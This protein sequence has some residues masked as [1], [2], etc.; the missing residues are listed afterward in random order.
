MKNLIWFII[1]ASTV[2]SCRPEPI[3]VRNYHVEFPATV[4]PAQDTFNIGDTI[5]YEL[6]VA[7][8]VE[9][10]QTSEWIDI[11]ML[12]LYFV[13]DISRFDTLYTNFSLYDFDY[14]VV[15]GNQQFSSISSSLIFNQ[16]D[17]KR[18]KIGLIPKYKGGYRMST[19]IGYEFTNLSTG[20][21]NFDDDCKE[22]LAYSTVVINNNNDNNTELLTGLYQIV[23]DIGDTLFFGNQ[24]VLKQ[25]WKHTYV[26]YVR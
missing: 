2:T 17:N 5:W 26:F 24:E 18:F 22:S 12:D 1:L 16:I 25:Q 14:V 11:S 20:A 3:C 8:E 7:N 6:N 15:E 9:D 23:E 13:M 21:V 19:S 10:T 4:Y